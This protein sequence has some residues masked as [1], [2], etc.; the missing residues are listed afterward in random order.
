MTRSGQMLAAAVTA[1]ITV[2]IL[3]ASGGPALAGGDWNDAGI[4]WMGYE[5]GLK[6]AAAEGRPVCLVF[7]TEWCPHCAT[8][9][10]V[11]SDPKVVEQS[12]KFVMIRLD[13]D[14]NREISR[15]YA[16]D[17]EYIPRTFFLSS[18]GKLDPAIHAPR[19]GY[20]YFYDES[21][22]VSILG[23]MQEALAKLAPAGRPSAPPE[24]AKPTPAAPGNPA[25]PKAGPAQPVP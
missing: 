15:Q 23:G 24:P 20:V 18:D 12:K 25:G 11:F 10:R 8:Y 21:A 22:P 19:Q 5:N 3:A 4:K 9:S 17:G 13:R 16:P 2:A 1:T 14:K 7:Y 6:A